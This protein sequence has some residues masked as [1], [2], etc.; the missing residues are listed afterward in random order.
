[1]SPLKLKILLHYL[2]SKIL[3][4]KVLED[5][6]GAYPYKLTDRGETYINAIL[7]QAGKIQYPE[8]RTMW[9]IPQ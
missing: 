7:D 1:M 4:H 5:I 9:V 2:T 3:L 6:G 8:K